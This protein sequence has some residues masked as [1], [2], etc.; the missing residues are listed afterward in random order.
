MFGSLIAILE[1]MFWKKKSPK[2]DPL[3]TAGEG[4]RIYPAARVFDNTG[5]SQKVKIGHCCWIMGEFLM[6]EEG[7]IEI[8]NHCYIGPGVKIWS[9]LPLKIG[10]RVFVSHGVN[11]HD[12]DSHSLSASERHARFFEK[13]AHG[14]H[15]LAEGK[16][17]AAIQIEDDVWIG[18]NSILLKGVRIGRGAVIG[19]GA[20]ITKN[21]DPYTVVVGNPQRVV[22]QSSA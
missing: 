18:F 19:A 1:I 12:T 20:V 11:I 8:G 5:R 15:L 22:G 7:R 13:M 3:F 16:K 6:E 2:P 17:H 14:R 10:D 21:V 4:T 9:S